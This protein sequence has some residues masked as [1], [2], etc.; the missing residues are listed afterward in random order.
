[1]FWL[2]KI[3]PTSFLLVVAVETMATEQENKKFSDQANEAMLCLSVSETPVQFQVFQM[4]AVNSLQM[5]RSDL[6]DKQLHYLVGYGTAKQEVSLLNHSINAN[7]PI[8]EFKKPMLKGCLN[9]FDPEIKLFE[10]AIKNF[11]K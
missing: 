9:K 4:I 8:K 7:T 3:I 2:K 5:V 6:D 10:S 11:S 1:M